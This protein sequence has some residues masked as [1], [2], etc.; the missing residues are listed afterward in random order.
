M[1]S[2]YFSVLLIALQ[3]LLVGNACA[4]KADSDKN[5]EIAAIKSED[6]DLK[7]IK[8][9]TGNVVLT[10]GTLIMKGTKLVITTTPDGWQFGTMYAPNGGLATMRQKR[11][12]GPDLWMEGE[13]ADRITWDQKTSVAILYTSA[14]VRRITGVK[15]TD[16]AEGAYLSYNSQ[17]EI[18]TGANS[19]SGESKTGDGRV[20]VT[21]QP[22][23]H[24]DTPAA[25]AQ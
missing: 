9:F 16:E 25:K 2:S 8:T 18:V 21:I 6:D 10:Q 19:E 24:S 1:K 17:T 20:K 13:A 11:D 14:K 22:K 5:I 4:E 7:G 12:G 3:I 23:N 15:P